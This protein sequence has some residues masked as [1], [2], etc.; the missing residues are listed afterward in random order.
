MGA[1]VQKAL[2]TYFYCAAIEH[3]ENRIIMYFE[4]EVRP[5]VLQPGVQQTQSARISRNKDRMDTLSAADG[6]CFWFS[7][8]ADVCRTLDWRTSGPISFSNSPDCV[9]TLFSECSISC[10][11]QGCSICMKRVLEPS[12][13]G[14]LNRHW[15]VMLCS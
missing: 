14:S 9:I 3:S 15:K 10:F 12:K 13:T 11:I 2:T 1:H 5:V 4:N 6:M 7:C 8:S